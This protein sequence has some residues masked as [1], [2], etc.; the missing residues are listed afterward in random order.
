LY[1]DLLADDKSVKGPDVVCFLG[2]LRYHLRGPLTIVWD[3]G[4]VHD[5]SGLV[6]TCLARHPEIHT[7]KFPSYAPELN[8]DE[9]VWNHTKYARLPNF[10]PDDTNHLRRRLRYELHRLRKR[11]DLLHSFIRHTKLPLGL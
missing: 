2:H 5:K 1:F 7:E 6:R 4:S 3:R 9:G 8:P 11:P 10:V